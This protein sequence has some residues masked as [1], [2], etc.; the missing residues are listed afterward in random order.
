VFAKPAYLIHCSSIA[1]WQ[2]R[3]K[4]P[5]VVW[6]FTNADRWQ[7]FR[8]KFEVL[9]Y[10]PDCLVVCIRAEVQGSHQLLRSVVSNI[11]LEGFIVAII[12]VG[13]ARTVIFKTFKWQ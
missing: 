7:W 6:G 2:H 8:Y 5:V 3:C 12:C 13:R 10:P 1:T 4:K 11:L 9:I